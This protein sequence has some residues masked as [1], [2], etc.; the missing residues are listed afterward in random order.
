[1]TRLAIY[2]SLEKQARTYTCHIR[3]EC[4]KGQ[5]NPPKHVNNTV[6][7]IRLYT[8][9]KTNVSIKKN[10]TIKNFSFSSLVIYRD[11]EHNW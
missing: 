6:A 3:S 10:A 7:G 8:A 4:T 5:G 1:M 9:F 2:C 11:S